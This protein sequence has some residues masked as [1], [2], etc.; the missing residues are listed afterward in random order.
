MDESL[1]QMA[2][3]IA[4]GKCGNGCYNCEANVVRKSG[5][6]IIRR[7]AQCNNADE[8]IDFVVNWAQ[9]NPPS[10]YPTWE[11]GWKI[12]FPN[13]VNG[14]FCPKNVFGERYAPANC[15]VQ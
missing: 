13:S 5:A 7:L 15:T 8:Q 12:M 14:A 11:K 9:M 4:D 3:R 1:H 2:L 6:C 10:N